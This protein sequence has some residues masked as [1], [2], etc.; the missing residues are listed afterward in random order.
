MCV[1]WTLRICSAADGAVLVAEIRILLEAPR[2]TDKI[3]SVDAASTR[4]AAVPQPGPFGGGQSAMIIPLTKRRP[5]SVGINVTG[6]IQSEHP[7]YRRN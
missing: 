7:P 3:I 2:T 5:Q 4:T 6:A 1:G